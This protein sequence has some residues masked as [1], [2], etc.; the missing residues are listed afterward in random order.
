MHVQNKKQLDR[1]SDFKKH[2]YQLELCQMGEIKKLAVAKA[3]Y[4]HG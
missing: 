1:Q 2:P 3:T 4:L